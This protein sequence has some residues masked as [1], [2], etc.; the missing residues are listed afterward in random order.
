MGETGLGVKD[1]GVALSGLLSQE[2]EISNQKQMRKRTN[3]W[4]WH[5]FMCKYLRCGVVNEDPCRLLWGTIKT[6]EVKPA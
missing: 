6:F 3:M 5:L 4:Q 1:C 2:Q